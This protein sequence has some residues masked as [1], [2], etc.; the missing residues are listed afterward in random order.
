MICVSHPDSDLELLPLLQ[1]VLD[2][3]W[4]HRRSEVQVRGELLSDGLLNSIKPFF[5]IAGTLFFWLSMWRLSDA[6]FI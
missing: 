4:T 3:E 6:H 1:S 2:P 5:T